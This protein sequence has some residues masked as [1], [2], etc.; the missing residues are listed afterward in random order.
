MKSA[1]SSHR[2]DYDA[3]A[4]GAAGGLVVATPDT[5]DPIPGLAVIPARSRMASGTRRSTACNFSS[6]LPPDVGQSPSH[7]ARTGLRDPFAAPTTASA[8]WPLSA[9]AV[10]Q[11]ITSTASTSGAASCA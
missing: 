10:G 11:L 8:A 4:G 1:P 9:T 5:P 2:Q 7:A 6:E 3:D